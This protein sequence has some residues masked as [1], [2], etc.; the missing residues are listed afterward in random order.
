M[1]TCINISDNIQSELKNQPVAD[2][3]NLAALCTCHFYLN[4]SK[5]S[6]LAFWYFECDRMRMT[7]SAHISW[8]LP[9]KNFISW[10]TGKG[11]FLEIQH[12]RGWSK[13][14]CPPHRPRSATRLCSVSRLR[15]GNYLGFVSTAQL[16]FRWLNAGLHFRLSQ[17]QA[18]VLNQKL[19]ELI[20]DP[21]PPTAEEL[22]N[23]SRA[24]SP[25]ALCRRWS[26][27]IDTTKHPPPRAWPPWRP[28]RTAP[29]PKHCSPSPRS[30]RV[31]RC[32]R[33]WLPVHQDYHTFRSSPWPHRRSAPDTPCSAS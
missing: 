13:P 23:R 21:P 31:G 24:E 33:T 17:E 11:V 12:G 26:E 28:N 25:A 6:C 32:R 8:W 27:W 3:H 14:R 18:H 10:A 2:C 29:K 16:A 5:T 30:T 1:K 9:G 7:N 4:Y 22:A 15:R 19:R 20:R